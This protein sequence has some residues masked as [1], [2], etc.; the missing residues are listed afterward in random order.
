ME[1]F[2]RGLKRSG[3]TAV[4][5]TLLLLLPVWIPLLCFQHIRLLQFDWRCVGLRLSDGLP[6]F[7]CVAAQSLVVLEQMYFGNNVCVYI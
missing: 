2:I 4:N 1:L 5:Y 6:S 7:G 3:G